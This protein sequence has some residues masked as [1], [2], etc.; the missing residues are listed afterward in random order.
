MPRWFQSIPTRAFI[1]LVV[2]NVLAAAGSEVT[3]P[4]ESRTRVVS[5]RNDVM[6]VL[7]KAGCN[8]GPC[9]GNQN[10]K[11]SFKLSLRG[12][13]P[14]WDYQAMTRDM[15][16]R[17]IDVMDPE[18]SLI[19][20]KPTT[21]L[22]HEGGLRFKKESEEYAI[23][24][25]WIAAGLP[26]DIAVAPRLT[27]LIVSPLE[28]IV[29]E[30]TNGVS[31]TTRALFSDGTERDV[32]RVAVYEP[33]STQVRVS[34]DGVVTLEHPGETTVLVRFLEQQAA[35]RLALV[36]ARPEF[37]WRKTP[38][39]N[40]IDREVLAKL[41]TLRMIPSELC[42]DP[43]FIRRVHLDLL[44]LLPTADEAR[45]FCAGPAPDKRE[46]LV[47]EL[48]EKPEFAEFWALKWSDVLRN[49]E[50]VLDRKGIQAFH[51]WIRQSLAQHKPIDQ[52]V[53]E[54]VAARG[55]TYENPPANFYRANRDAVTRAE[56]TAQLFLGTRLQCAKCHNHPFDR[57]TQGDYYDWATVFARVNY[58]VLENERRDRLDSHEFVGEQI[59]YLDREG[60]LTNPRTGQPAKARFLGQPASEPASAAGGPEKGKARPAKQSA[61]AG[62]DVS[63]LDELAN[64]LVAQTNFARAQ[65]NW[66]W[67]QIMG[68]G[69]VDPIDDFR[70]TNPPSHPELLDGLAREFA[71]QKFDLHRL[72][73]F[74]MASRTY[75]LSARPNET[76]EGDEINYS[77]TRPRRLTAEQLL[78][79]QQQFLEV[80]ASFRGYPTGT[81]AAQLPG[82]SPVRRNEVKMGGAE[83][84]L[85][86]FGKPSRLLACECERSSETTLGQTFQLISSPEMNSLLTAPNNRLGRL[87]AAGV[88]DAGIVD[89]LY[90]AALTRPPSSGELERATNLL[91]EAPDKRRALED[92][93]WALLNAKESV[94]RQ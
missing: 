28:R 57:W 93:A 89:E 59:V 48:L 25:D 56:A 92:I 71:R 60:G 44:G 51:G 17:R 86:V 27:R 78:D 18:E 39:N 9:H 19:L 31:L 14:A 13:D 47:A 85:S 26:D 33:S 66:V 67:Y 58:K 63:E 16:A 4:G 42:S 90:W 83:K 6:P 91:R 22:A 5:F 55:S 88:S 34:H 10:G 11:A 7:S 61:A 20:L 65:V 81:R 76:N 21:Q 94:L 77:H 36:P 29:I 37:V 24:R 73:R 3:R 32:T 15:L 52:F 75:Q 8:S 82:G 79:T 53:R 68:R 23:L 45:R 74:I 87:L 12:E 62:Q 46:R 69:I 35:V 2:L 38:A 49:E 50:K 1:G 41:R 72:I 84:F 43:E 70:P 64:W 54:I 40:F 80:P 30:P